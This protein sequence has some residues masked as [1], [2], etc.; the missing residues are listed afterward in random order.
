M[1]LLACGFG[2]AG[3]DQ[4]PVSYW[5]RLFGNLSVHFNN[6][7]LCSYIHA[8]SRQAVLS[9]HY[10]RFARYSRFAELSVSGNLFFDSALEFLEYDYSS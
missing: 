3:T 9:S 7:N 1:E 2:I 6:C 5:Y 8:F 4:S 10:K